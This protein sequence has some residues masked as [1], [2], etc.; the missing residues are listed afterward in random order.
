MTRLTLVLALVLG[1]TAFGQIDDLL[2]AGP[3]SKPHADLKGLGN[4][5][6]CHPSGKQLSQQACLA[7][8]DELTPRIAKGLGLHGHIKDD[9]RA[10][11]SCH[12]EHRGPEFD[13]I[14]YGPNGKKGFDHQ[15]TGWTLKGKHADTKC[16]DCH[17]K[18]LM[19]A[20]AVK[21]MEKRPRTQLGLST[22]CTDCHF[23]EHRGQQQEDCEYCHV[24][25]GWK[26]AP[27]FN[28]D[29]TQYPLRGKHVK[30]KC[31]GCHDT[32][33]DSE[34]HGFP[35]PKNET[36]LRFAPVEHRNCI[37]CHKDWHATQSTGSFG[38][39][40][41]S[42]H[43]VE[44]WHIIR[45]G[46]EERKF[47]DKTNFPLKGAHVD[48]E[49]N[50]CHG[51]YPGVPHKLKPIAHDT[52]ND[53]HADAHEGQLSVN[54]KP[55]DC[56]KCHTEAAFLPAKY[57]LADHQKTKY[58]LEGAHQVVACAACH[59]PTPALKAKIPK[60]LLADLKRRHR[61]ELF[62]PA[63]FE[64]TKP[65]E[66]CDSCHTDVHKGQFKDKA[67]DGC[68]Q[69]SSFSRVKFDHDKDSRFPLE[70]GHRDVKCE[71]CH[72]AATPK[73]VVKYKPLDQSCKSCHLDVHVGQFATATKPCETC[74]TATKWKTL[75][76][77]H[78]PPFTTYLL[79][80]QH[81]KAKC[82]SCH[83]PVEVA[84]G[85]KATRY[86]PLPQTCEACHSDFHKGEFQG[87]EP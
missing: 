54:G 50:S 5:S 76:F 56:T 49:C 10:C 34:A 51:G 13:L 12:P 3:L 53:C 84:A 17:E 27:G 71:K 75:L 32:D 40:C 57:T 4:C 39:R 62:S 60:T 68:H 21:L 74:H 86:K 2:S 72:Y 77:K 20:T 61:D 73:D 15:R 8:H 80:G 78:E 29:D 7:C 59:A 83:K 70:S 38:P 18:R 14:D 47:H 58:S 33:K 44:D 85:V 69:V 6:K 36:F 63:L 81:A 23:D 37:D 24:E 35:A 43:T 67:C 31:T 48:V 42:C 19:N 45:K 30:V 82:E 65:N 25:K 46:A 52:C 11:Q 66:K 79:D 28:H 87:F 55:P 1:G 26:P 16:V 22:G 9:K 64:F 41:Q